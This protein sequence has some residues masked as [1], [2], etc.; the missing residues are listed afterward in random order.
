MPEG[1]GAKRSGRPGGAKV[2]PDVGVEGMLRLFVVHA[3]GLQVGIGV[4]AALH[5]LWGRLVRTP[6][7]N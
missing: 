4:G 2:E 6:A 1:Y 3:A 7:G 5:P